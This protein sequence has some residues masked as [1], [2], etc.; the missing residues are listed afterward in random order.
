[1]KVTLLHLIVN[2]KSIHQ[3]HR[4]IFITIFVGI[5]GKDRFDQWSSGLSVDFSNWEDYHP[6]LSNTETWCTSISRDSDYK[7]SV[8][9]C[10]W[11]TAYICKAPGIQAN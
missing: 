9:R 4:F 8:G 10:D 5:S 1:M 11:P 6:I 2:C 3:I 7:W